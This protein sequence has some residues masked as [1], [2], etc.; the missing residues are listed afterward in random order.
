[1][2]LA[3]LLGQTIEIPE[4]PFANCDSDVG[5]ADNSTIEKVVSYLENGKI[6][7]WCQ[8]K[9]EIGPRALGHR[10]ILMN[11]SIP[12]GKDILNSRVKKRESWR[13]FAASILA[14]DTETITGQ[15]HLYPYM[16][17]ATKVKESFHKSLKSVV[18]VD[19][20]CRFQSVDKSSKTLKSFYQLIKA[21]KEKTSIPGILNTSYNMAGMPIANSRKDILEAFRTLD[22][23]VLCIGNEIIT[24]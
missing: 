3:L 21:F 20:T 17:H 5:Y 24:K 1:M 9:S 12:D 11:P 14:E 6:V 23:D 22:L 8:G 16:L 7:G 4:F 10:S 2:F 18:H 13:P 15:K 19:N